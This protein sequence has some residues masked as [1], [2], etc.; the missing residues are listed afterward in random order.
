MVK[1]RRRH[2]AAC[3][4]RVALEALESSKP[5]RAGRIHLDAVFIP[6]RGLGSVDL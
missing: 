5:N 1:R 2:T 4:F 3:K 6:L